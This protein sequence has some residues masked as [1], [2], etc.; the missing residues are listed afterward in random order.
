MTLAEFFDM[1]LYLAIA[2]SVNK[3]FN[4]HE[5]VSSSSFKY[6]L[7]ECEKLLGGLGIWVVSLCVRF[8]SEFVFVRGFVYV[9]E[10][11]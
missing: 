10:S 9:C 6:L 2:L 8:V 11:L 7:C 3:E 4:M 1:C 5:W